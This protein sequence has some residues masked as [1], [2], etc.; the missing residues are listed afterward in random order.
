MN[1]PFTASE[2]R[3]EASWHASRAW[4]KAGSETAS[5]MLHAY[6]DRLAADEKAQPVAEIIAT[7]PETHPCA[8][9]D[10]DIRWSHEW[11]RMPVGTKLY[12]HPA[13]ADT[14]RLAELK[15]ILKNANVQGDARVIGKAELKRALEILATH[16]AQAQPPTASVPNLERFVVIDRAALNRMLTTRDFSELM[17]AAQEDSNENQFL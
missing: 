10:T 8:S 11:E 6:A 1:K 12:T 9:G 2:V 3:A 13:P 14:E 15:R 4:N 5:Q 16:S 7:P 17:R